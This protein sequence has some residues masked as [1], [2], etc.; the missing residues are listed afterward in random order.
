MDD[1][2]KTP[3]KEN[4]CDNKTPYLLTGDVYQAAQDSFNA[5]ESCDFLQLP[6]LISTIIYIDNVSNVNKLMLR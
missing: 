5:D 1:H 4:Y 6:Q 2:K 3:A